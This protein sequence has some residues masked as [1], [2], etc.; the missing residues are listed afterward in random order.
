MSASTPTSIS[1]PT[2]TSS[3]QPSF[4]GDDFS[5]NLFTDLGPLL[6]LFGAD[7][8]TQ[9]M[10]QSLGWPDHILFAIGPLGVVTAIVSAIRVG[11]PSWLRAFIGRAREPRAEIERALMS[12]TSTE[13]CEIWS[14]ESLVRV[15]GQPKMAELLL[16]FEED[17]RRLLK[18]KDGVWGVYLKEECEFVRTRPRT[19]MKPRARTS[20]K[21]P[22]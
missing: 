8:T 20:M 4:K 5:N 2:T 21:P 22:T 6:A 3:F 9:F 15:I 14:G 17:H 19:I 1:Q 13:V 12:S 11:G 7:V 16:V 10:S 18:S